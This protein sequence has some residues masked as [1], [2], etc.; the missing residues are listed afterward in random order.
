MNGLPGL[1]NRCLQFPDPACL[2]PWE[3]ER[4]T[5]GRIGISHMGGRPETGVASP[6]SQLGEPCRLRAGS[7]VEEI[8]CPRATV[9]SVDS[10][11]K[12]THCQKFLRPSPHPV[13]A[14]ILTFQVHEDSDPS[15][16]R[17]ACVQGKLFGLPGGR[18]TSTMGLSWLPLHGAR[19]APIDDP[20]HDRQDPT[21]GGR[22][23]QH[24]NHVPNPRIK[25]H[26]SIPE[27]QAPEIRAPPRPALDRVKE[28]RGDVLR[29]IAAPPWEDHGFPS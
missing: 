2:R 27:V 9:V 8:V 10:G 20:I 4:K 3:I 25:L 15:V 21:T 1:P 18:H 14:D 12:L 5:G 26:M 22:G 13:Y 19:P 24:W 29:E 23:A 11:E 6:N 7:I 17:D 28:R 16:W